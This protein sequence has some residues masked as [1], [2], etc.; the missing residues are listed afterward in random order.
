MY[1][2]IGQAIFYEHF[3]YYHPLHPIKASHDEASNTIY[4]LKLDVITNDDML[5][6]LSRQRKVLDDIKN[7]RN[8]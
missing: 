3:K 1:T 6:V 8:I 4:E 2:E 7:E 5:Q